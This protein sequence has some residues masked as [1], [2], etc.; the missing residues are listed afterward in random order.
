[1]KPYLSEKEYHTYEQAFATNKNG[2]DHLNELVF[3]PMY[4]FKS[5]VSYLEYCSMSG[6]LS[7]I[8]VPT[9]AL[10]AV[11]DAMCGDFTLPRKEI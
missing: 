8:Q 10:S 1:M 6:R 9:F 3:E 5:H 11:D 7:N 4:G 2:I